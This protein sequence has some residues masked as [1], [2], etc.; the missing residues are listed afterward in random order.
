MIVKLGSTIWTKS[1]SIYLTPNECVAAERA[2][3]DFVDGIGNNC[4]IHLGS[5]IV[6]F[7]VIES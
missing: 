2:V 7:A 4:S 1:F 6:W 5:S 3:K